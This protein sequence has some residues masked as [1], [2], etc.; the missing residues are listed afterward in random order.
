MQSVRT[1]QYA[2]FD[3]GNN[4]RQ[5]HHANQ[6][7]FPGYGYPTN[8]FSTISLVSN[9]QTE[10]HQTKPDVSSYGTSTDSP[11]HSNSIEKLQDVLSRPLTMTPQEKIEKLRRRQQMQALLAIQQQQQQFGQEGSGSDT[12]VPQS[13]SPRNK[14]PDSLASSIVIDENTNDFFP[15]ELIP[16][17]HKEVH[18]SSSVSDDPFIEEKIYYQLQNAL[19]KA[20]HYS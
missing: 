18:K 7:M 13:Y 17:S 19:D 14:N 16:S 3:D 10:D 1:H 11:K 15:H 6:F 8:P 5:V 12:M 4:M 9:M 20:T 2:L